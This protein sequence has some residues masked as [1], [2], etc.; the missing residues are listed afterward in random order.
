MSLAGHLRNEEPRRFRLHYRLIFPLHIFPSL[1]I[2]YL[3]RGCIFHKVSK[4]MYKEVIG[5]VI[6]FTLELRRLEDA[7]PAGIGLT[8]REVDN[9]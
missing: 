2:L 4:N 5:L 8:L 6:A 7:T 9:V 1:V 3:C